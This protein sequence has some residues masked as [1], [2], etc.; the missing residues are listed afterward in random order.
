MSLRF[1]AGIAVLVG[2]VFAAVTLM[3]RTVA[4]EPRPGDADSGP[5]AASQARIDL[6]AGSGEI[7]RFGVAPPIGSV[8]HMEWLGEDAARGS[9]TATVPIHDLGD[10]V[11]ELRF[12]VSVDTEVG[13][14]FMGPWDT[15]NDGKLRQSTVQ[16]NAAELANGQLVGFRPGTAWHDSR[17]RAT[18]AAKA[19]QLIRLRCRATVPVALRDRTGHRPAKGSSAFELAK[20]FRRGVNLGNFLEVPPGEDWGDNSTGPDDY[21]RMKQ[22]GFDH[23][24]IPVGW[25]HY[26]GP[27]PDYRI[28]AAIVRQVN[29]QLDLARDAGLGAIVNIHHFEAFTDDPSGQRAKLAGLWRQIATIAKDRPLDVG[30]EILN[31]PANAATT[32]VMNDVYAEVIA[33]IRK[34][35][36]YRAIFVGPGQFNRISELPLLR[37]PDDERL[38]VTVHSYTP[39]EF[40]HQGAIWSDDLKRLRGVRFPGPPERKVATAPGVPDS[41]KRWIERYNELPA[42]ENPG[43]VAAVAAELKMAFDWGKHWNRP[44]H[45][46]EFGVYLKAEPADRARYCEAVR[47]L[48]DRLE[49]GWCVWDWKAGFAFWDSAKGAP[50]EGLRR[51]LFA[52]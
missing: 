4:E 40:T 43:G 28:D 11:F 8:G 32:E 47:R 41:V 26:C 45:L 37:L 46:G 15:G 19:G 50:H 33:E 49:I 22:A 7:E 23:V 17:I 39:F 2:S 6:V 38:I 16:W 25:H 20:S 52:Q 24:R 14:D 35:D 10:T 44:I 1:L 42:D 36:P 18:F 9:A 30:L 21:R 51:A 29:R 3:G 48:C 27:A 5:V 31:E 34:I 12:R 13:V